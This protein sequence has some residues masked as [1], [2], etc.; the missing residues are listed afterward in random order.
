[1]GSLG[2]IFIFLNNE[3]AKVDV[4]KISEVEADKIRKEFRGPG[5]P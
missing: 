5:I 3:L 1:M 4:T 2:R